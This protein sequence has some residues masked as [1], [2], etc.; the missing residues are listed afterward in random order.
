MCVHLGL[1]GLNVLVFGE[2]LAGGAGGADETDPKQRYSSVTC[3]TVGDI[4]LCAFR[5]EIY[6]LLDPVPN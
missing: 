5:I 1:L 6:S 4:Q 3:D 2:E